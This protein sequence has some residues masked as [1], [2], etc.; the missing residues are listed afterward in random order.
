MN[1]FLHS[2]VAAPR[3]DATVHF[4]A[5]ARP[6][7]PVRCERSSRPRRGLARSVGVMA[8]AAGL[9]LSCADAGAVDLNTAT[10]EQLQALRGIGPK[11]A[12]IIVQERTR[13]GRFES[14]EDLSDRVRGIGPKRLQQL[15]AA[16]LTVGGQDAKPAPAK[17]QPSQP[18]PGKPGR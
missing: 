11:T 3:G 14:L 16:G 13:A 2:C 18:S 17:P 15:Q 5:A 8:L 1:P 4:R 9:G 10:A 6:C 12:Q 7:R